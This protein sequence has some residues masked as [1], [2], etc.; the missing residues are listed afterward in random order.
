MP[1][2]KQEV[3]VR[4]ARLN[5]EPTREAA[6]VEE[7]SQHLEQRMEE[8]LAQG[9]A[10][11]AAHEAVLK[12]LSEG[13]RL[14]KELLQVEKQ[15]RFEPALADPSTVRGMLAH[16]IKDFRHGLRGLRLN[17][18]FASVAIMSL[19]L[20][21]GAN[22]AIFQLLDA[23]RLRSLPVSHPE[24]LM[25]VAVSNS[26]G[27]S[28]N[29]RGSFPMF[30]N[31]I[32]ERVRDQ[33][34]AFSSMAAW[35]SSNFNLAP[36]GRFR[37]GRGMYVNGD[38][39]KTLGVSAVAGRVFTAS[40]DTR[41]CGLPG[42]VISYDFWQKEFAGKHSAIGS[43]I[44]LDGHPVEVIG[45]TPASFYGV[46]VSRGFDIAVPIC[47]EA[48]IDGE[49]KVLDRMDGWWLAFLGR[50]KPGWTPARATTQLE[51]ISS[52][53]FKETLPAYYQNE[54]AKQYLDWKLAARPASSGLSNLRRNYEDPL[55]ILL[56]I[57]GTVLL[58]ACA[59]LAN[60]MFARANA[61]EREIAVRLA[62][63]APRRRLLQQL[64]TESLLLSGI[65]AVAG[66]LLAQGLTRALVAFL[67]TQFRSVTLDLGLD[68]RVLGFTAAVAIL[69]CLLFG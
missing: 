64:M 53:I 34:Q 18:G 31:P 29:F 48:L 8:L 56:G 23:V 7:M 24:E 37:F 2:F 42:A 11:A 21:I 61:R 5:L 67:S 46:E 27:R 16:L 43:K 45:V 10:P 52:S 50:L 38:F 25:Q 1:D 13:G 20:G 59:N 65:G 14:E 12:E 9:L 28:G 33:Q 41:G 49:F 68:W 19:A 3:R 40:D 51:T 22:T 69:T 62:L 35:N 57:A 58:I 55:W 66:I 30:T 60:L 26:H 6:I 32:W 15:L 47:S 44:T 63:G 39:F 54:L 36:G 17:P 4:V